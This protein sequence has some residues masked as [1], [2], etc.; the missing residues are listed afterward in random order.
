MASKAAK[1][2]AAKRFGPVRPRFESP[3]NGEHGPVFSA[4]VSDEGKLVTQG[5]LD[6]EEIGD[7]I[8]WLKDQFFE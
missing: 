4:F 8:K 1:F 7:F 5:S 3:Q 2:A 6:E